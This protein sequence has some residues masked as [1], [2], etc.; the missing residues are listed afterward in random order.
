M[1]FKQKFEIKLNDINKNQKIKNKALFECLENIAARHA[2]SI[3]HGIKDIPNIGTTWMLLCW[4]LEV[5]KRPTYG[6]TL[7]IHTWARGANKCFTYRDFEIYVN[8][9]KCVIAAS[10]WLLLDIKRGR[11]T[12]V[13]DEILGRYQPEYG[14]SVF[15]IDEIEKL[16]EL[17]NYDEEA[18][19]S[20]RKSDIDI[21]GHMHNLNYLDIVDEILTQKEM[22]EE[23]DFVRIDYRKEI[24]IDDKIEILKKVENN[25]YYFL[26]KDI[27]TDLVHAIVEMD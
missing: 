26:I 24:K 21:N 7:E 4:Q 10:K 5:L 3:N 22:Q 15:N 6:D 19:F 25:K 18:K 23:F 20:V 8:G 14:K 12:R 9:E 11:P 13:G 1:I 17:E 2:D 27:D 16:K